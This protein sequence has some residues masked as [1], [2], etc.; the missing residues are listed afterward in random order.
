MNADEFVAKM[1]AATTEAE[2][3]ALAKEYAAQAER[4]AAEKVA[5]K[6]GHKTKVVEKDDDWYGPFPRMITAVSLLVKAADGS[7][8]ERGIIRY[9]YHN[10]G[11][12]L[13]AT[14]PNCRKPVAFDEFH[15]SGGKVFRCPSCGY[16]DRL[17]RCGCSNDCIAISGKCFKRHIPSGLALPD[18]WYEKH[19]TREEKNS[20]VPPLYELSWRDDSY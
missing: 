14:C 19:P 11:H 2:R 12:P 9:V 16:T 20:I 7:E 6:R 5:K 1:L 3:Q 4:K 8:Q 18:N 13:V 15:L 10:V 17:K